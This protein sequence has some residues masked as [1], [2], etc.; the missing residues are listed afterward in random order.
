MATPMAHPDPDPD[1]YLAE[2]EASIDQLLAGRYSEV[3]K[4]SDPLTE[5]LRALADMIMARLNNDL[6]RTVD[7]SVIANTGVTRVAEMI[8][9]VREVDHR[10][11]SIAAAIEELTASVNSIAENADSAAQE[12]QGVAQTAHSGK[13]ASDRAQETMQ[14]IAQAVQTAAGRVDTLSEASDQIGN[15][16]QE[17]EAI[18]KQ[19]NLLAL[20]AT[21]EAARSGEAGKGFA[22]VANEVKNLALQTAKAT[23]EIRARIESLRSE[24]TGIVESMREGAEKVHAG[25][26]VIATTG[27]EMNRVSGQVETVNQKMQEIAGILAQQTQATH[28]ISDGV[29]MIAQMST[30]NVRSIENVITVLEE[31]EAPVVESINS[32]VER[33][34][35][36]ATVHAA[37]S[38]HMIWMRKLAQMLVGRVSLD[39]DELADHHSC[40]LGR[41][42]DQ[43][44]DPA[45]TGHPAW[46]ALKEPHRKVHAAGIEAAKR[47]QANDLTGAIEKV[48]EAGKASKEVMALLDRL[49][50]DLA[51]ES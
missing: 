31:T 38:D 51:P 39:P 9:S 50:D 43:Q 1:T 33:G 48:R 32:F 18:A 22:V 6:R 12:A 21:I 14:E 35:P 47:Y 44:T 27:E 8:R 5:K 37:K 45:L 29:S 36:Y 19:T 11:Q 4:G 2:V 25:Q 7:M 13:A 40:R 34:I 23:E 46:D 15:M 26:E 41:W 42:Y 24:M 20:N 28:E 49:T 30:E 3:P 16:V 10:A 17:I